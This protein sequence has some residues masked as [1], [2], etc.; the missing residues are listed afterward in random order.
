MRSTRIVAT[1]V[2]L[3][4]LLVT[5]AGQAQAPAAPAAAAQSGPGV[6][7]PRDSR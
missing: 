6:Q 2:A 5:A 3:S 7:A 4:A 1:T